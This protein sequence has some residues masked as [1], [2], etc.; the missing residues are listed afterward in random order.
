M[1]MRHIAVRNGCATFTP[2]PGKKWP[3]RTRAKG[4]ETIRTASWSRQV[5][6]CM[7]RTC[8]WLTESA[9]G[10]TRGVPHTLCGRLEI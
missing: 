2:S 1:A 4:E 8:A 7:D 3:A 6:F 9:N 10:R 5:E